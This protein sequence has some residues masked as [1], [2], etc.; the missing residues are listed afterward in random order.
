[1]R[2]PTIRP[3]LQLRKRVCQSGCAIVST[4][5]EASGADA[6]AE[7]AAKDLDDEDLDEEGRVGRV[8]QSRGRTGDADR[9][10]AEQVAEADGQ[11]APEERES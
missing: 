7:D 11:T 10:A 5:Q 2:R 6:Q 4:T 1:M 8:R 9:D 3:N